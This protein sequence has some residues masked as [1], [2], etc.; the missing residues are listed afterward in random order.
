M[1]GNQPSWGEGWTI[2]LRVWIE[3]AGQ[4][5]L[6]QGRAELL[7][8]IERWHSISAAA[9]Q[10]GMSYRHAWRPASPWCRRRP[11]ASAAAGPD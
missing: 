4:A 8:G 11:E 3:R 10:L 6:G 1:P 2:G 9:R 7:D 5:I